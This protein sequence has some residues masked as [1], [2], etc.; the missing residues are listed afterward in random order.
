MFAPYLVTDS[1]G[2]QK[3]SYRRKSSLHTSS[4][5]EKKYWQC[6]D[7]ATSEDWNGNF[8]SNGKCCAFQTAIAGQDFA[9]TCRPSF[10]EVKLSQK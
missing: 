3:N 4:R 2:F 7:C 1:A 5:L 6:Y 9:G 8:C 10:G